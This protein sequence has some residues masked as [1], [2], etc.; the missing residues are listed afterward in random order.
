MVQFQH[1]YNFSLCFSVSYCMI[2]TL[3]QEEMKFK[4]MIKLNHNI[5]IHIVTKCQYLTSCVTVVAVMMIC[6][7]L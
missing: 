2:M 6:T 5:D 3:K 7:G 1:W 4:P